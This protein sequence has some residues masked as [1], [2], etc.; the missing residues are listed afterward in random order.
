MAF[1]IKD[2]ETDRVV[3]ELA[4]ATGET[5]TD[6]VGNAAREK[7]QRFPGRGERAAATEDIR[8]IVDRVS[9]L[10]VLDERSAEEI[11]GYDAHGLPN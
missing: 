10:P 5:L 11:L 2:E 1:N 4:A 8:R 9:R 3:R 7:L 6:A